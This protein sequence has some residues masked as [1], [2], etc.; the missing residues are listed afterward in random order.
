MVCNEGFI[1]Q[2]FVVQ[3]LCTPKKAYL[4]RMALNRLLGYN[5]SALRESCLITV[6]GYP[7]GSVPQISVVW[8]DSLCLHVTY[9]KCIFLP[10]NMYFDLPKLTE[11]L[12]PQ[13]LPVFYLYVYLFVN[14]FK[15]VIFLKIIVMKKY[16]L[17]SSSS[18]RYVTL[19]YI[20]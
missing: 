15:N 8:P 13:L 20:C 12:L 5:L 9:G 4:R 16:L 2:V 18:T 6:F 7:L 14:E 3:V 10:E 19:Q 17:S 11:I 1:Q